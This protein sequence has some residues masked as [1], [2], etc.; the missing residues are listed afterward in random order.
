MV[1]LEIQVTIVSGDF[2]FEVTDVQKKLGDLF[3]HYGKLKSGEIKINE[4]V[5]MKINDVEEETIQERII[6]LH[7]YYMSL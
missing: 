4:N 1:R 2:V 6:Q 5:E 3:V 7:I